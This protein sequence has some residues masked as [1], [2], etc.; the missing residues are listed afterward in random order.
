MEELIAHTL[1]IDQDKVNIKATYFEGLGIIVE[2][3]GLGSR[4]VVLLEKHDLRQR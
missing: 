1:E 3:K 2:G 4:A